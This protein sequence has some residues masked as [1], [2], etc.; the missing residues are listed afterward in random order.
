M[1]RQDT[2]YN[3]M[4]SC[5]L[6]TLSHDC[7]IEHTCIEL[8]IYIHVYCVHVVTGGGDARGIK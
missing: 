7:D 4:S 6:A 2:N 1:H 5:I 8:E 3:F